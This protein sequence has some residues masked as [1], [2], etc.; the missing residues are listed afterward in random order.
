MKTLPCCLSALLAAAIP[1]RSPA[2][3]TTTG[4]LSPP[5]S[6]PVSI[7]S[8]SLPP[9]PSP[10][11]AAADLPA[12]R[13][14]VTQISEVRNGSGSGSTNL[15][16]AI[17]GEG[18]PP[19]AGVRQVNLTRAEDNLGRSLASTTSA[20]ASSI[21]LSRFKS[22]LTSGRGGIG[23]LQGTAAL[24]MAARKAT[25]LAFIEGTIEI[26]LPSEANGSMLR[27]PN[28]KDHPGRFEEATLARQGIELTL[29]TDDSVAANSAAAAARLL[30]LERASV[31]LAVMPGPDPNAPAIPLLG[32]SLK[33]PSGN[34]L[35]WQLQDGSGAIIRSFSTGSSSP[36]GTNLVR[37]EWPTP[38]P[39]DAQ[40]V[41][42]RLTPE[43]IKTV[44]FRVEDIPLP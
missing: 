5:S 20:A 9:A 39:K 11:A 32:F 41:I 10:T 6:A 17:T 40:L 44:P 31:G 23:P 14:G 22:A 33:D 30:A 7:S 26:Y 24:G 8:S 1:A 21:A 16:L 18:L 36:S 3:T 15:T 13:V 42:F 38:L 43:S 37:I 34:F 27:I 4:R 25:S 35:A 29:F 2:Q 12:L 19:T 28:F